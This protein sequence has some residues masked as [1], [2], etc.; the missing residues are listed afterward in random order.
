MSV[1][2]AEL[3]A[4]LQGVQRVIEL[5]ISPV[6]L[7]TDE[8]EV[9]QAITTEEYGLSTFDG[10]IKDIKELVRLNFS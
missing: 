3:I 4:C 8:M 10:L 1:F 7:P 2:Q 9:Q 5:G 6:V